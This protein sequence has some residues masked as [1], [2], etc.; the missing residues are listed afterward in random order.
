MRVDLNKTE[1]GGFEFEWLRAAMAQPSMGSEWGECLQVMRRIRQNQF[2]SWISQ[3]ADL[4]LSVEQRGRHFQSLSDTASAGQ[5]FM[6]ASNY[7]RCAEFFANH[8]N[9]R[10]KHYWEKSRENFMAAA[11]QLNIPVEPVTI[12]FNQTRLPGY[13]IKGGEGKRPTLLALSGFDG[14]IE[15]LY[16]FIGK[17]ARDRGWHCLLFSG[18]GQRDALHLNPGLVFRPDY[19][20]PVASVVNYVLTIPEVD[21]EQLAIIG[22]SFGGYFASRA[23]A[24]NPR[25]KACVANS[26]IVGGTQDLVPF[27]L[28]LFPPS[29]INWA[30]NALSKISPGLRWALENGRWTFG[31]ENPYDFITTLAPYTLKG[32]EER[33][34]APLLCI[35]GEQEF[36][37]G[38][39]NSPDKIRDIFHYIETVPASVW[40]KLFTRESGGASHCQAMGGMVQAQETTMAWL[41]QRFQED[42]APENGKQ[43]ILCSS[44]IPALKRHFGA[45]IALLFEKFKVDHAL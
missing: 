13:F 11:K 25:I 28:R 37:S 2:D 12:P 31:S 39:A 5:C 32:T 19:E 34:Q 17:A 30:V 41:K 36:I 33:M 9:P 44:F 38:P 43:V 3:W 10:Q 14:S 45:K 35:F 26:L 18:P 23:A 20:V 21:P 24:G 1:I 42:A 16:H 4:A 40:I 8:R 29:T 22:Y 27:P 7:Y 15:E 6:R